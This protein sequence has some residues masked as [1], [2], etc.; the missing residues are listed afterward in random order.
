MEKIRHVNAGWDCLFFSILPQEPDEKQP[1]NS[2]IG[3]CMIQY[4]TQGGG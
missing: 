3:N 2:M 4:I 1:E